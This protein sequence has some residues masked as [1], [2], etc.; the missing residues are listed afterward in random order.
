MVLIAIYSILKTIDILVHYWGRGLE[1]FMVDNGGWSLIMS[2][3]E[4][5]MLRFKAEYNT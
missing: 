2:Y 3:N 1:K 4:Q 5:C